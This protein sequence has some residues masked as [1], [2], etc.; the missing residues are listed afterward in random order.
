MKRLSI[1]SRSSAFTL[2]EVLTAVAVL[3][4]LVLI[5]AQML[6]GASKTVSVSETHMDVEGQV[7]TIFATMSSDFANLLKRSDAEV[8]VHKM[9]STDSPPYNDYMF[10][11]S[12]TPGYFDSTVSTYNRSPLSVI[13]YRINTSYQFE[14]FAKGLMWA[15][16][17]NTTTTGPVFLTYPTSYQAIVN[18]SST[19]QANSSSTMETKWPLE[20]PQPPT[21]LTNYQAIGQEIFRLEICF[22]LND[23]TISDTPYETSTSSTIDAS[24]Q[25]GL[26][27][28]RAVIVTVALINDAD[29]KLVTNMGKLVSVF[30]DSNIVTPTKTPTLP[31][32]TWLTEINSGHFATDAGIPLRVATEIRV[33]QQF[34]YVGKN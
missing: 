9:A 11:Y 27:D 26:Q 25:N 2:V 8:I 3:S 33:Y 13:G 10:F 16:D 4:I 29:R 31:A 28:V 15:D 30:P 7:R 32:T 12:E 24:R 23:G 34:F 20:I 14:R 17:A 19:A 22:L 1:H 5:I 21:T 18:T 6:S